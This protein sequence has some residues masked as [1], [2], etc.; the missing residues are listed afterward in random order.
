[1]RQDPVRPPGTRLI[2]KLFGLDNLGRPPHVRKRQA[3]VRD[4]RGQTHIREVREFGYSHD[5]ERTGYWGK[6][7]AHGRRHRDELLMPVMMLESE[8]EDI[9][10]YPRRQPYTQRHLRRNSEDLIGR[11]SKHRRRENIPERYRSGRRRPVRDH[12]YRDESSD[13]DLESHG[14]RRRMREPKHGRDHGPLNEGRE[15]DLPPRYHSPDFDPMPWHRLSHGRRRRMPESWYGQDHGPLHEDREY[16]L[17]PR[18]HSPDP[19]SMPGRDLYEY[20]PESRYGYDPRGI[21]DDE[22]DYDD[23]RYGD[24]P[25]GYLHVH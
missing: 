24:Y 2:E 8:Y 25:H 14:R 12:S 5:D 13:N 11:Q 21:S 20:P 9:F 23:E 3:F 18:Y 6:R 1:M 7:L 4:S 10:G 19:Y 15:Y 16:G 22:S 17:P